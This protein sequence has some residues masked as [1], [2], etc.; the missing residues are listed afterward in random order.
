[1]ISQVLVVLTKNFFKIRLP[2]PGLKSDQNPLAGLVNRQFG[3]FQLESSLPQYVPNVPPKRPVI[4]GSAGTLADGT[5]NQHRVG[6]HFFNFP[7]SVTGI[8]KSAPQFE[9]NWRFA[10]GS[11]NVRPKNIFEIIK[12]QVRRGIKNSGLGLGW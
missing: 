5:D 3:W 7:D 11:P 4:G 12:T 2:F 9:S 1:M 6:F 10:W 8:R